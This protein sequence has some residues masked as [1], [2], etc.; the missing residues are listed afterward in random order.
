MVF[1][2]DKADTINALVEAINAIEHEL[3]IV[4]SGVYFD[5]R[6]RL[7]I[8]EARINNPN[9]PGPNAEN[10]FYIGN[11]GVTVSVGLGFPT[12]NRTPG[13][14]Y[15][16]QDGYAHEGFYS[17]RPDGYWYQIDNTVTFGGD[18][19]GGLLSQTVI[20][21]QGKPISSTAPSDGY[22]LIYNSLATQ[23]QPSRLAV[24][25]DPINYNIRSN[26][27]LLQSPINNTKVG[28]INFGTDTTQL[29]TGVTSNYGMILGGDKNVVS[30]DHGIVIGGLNNIVNSTYSIILDGYN[31][32]I[33]D[34]YT[35]SSITGIS[36]TIS[37]NYSN[38]WG[39]NNQTIADLTN[40]FGKKGKA[41]Y[42]GQ[43]VISTD[44]ISGNNGASQ[45]S[46][47]IVDGYGASGSQFDL[48][49]SNGNSNIN[50]ENGKSYDM[51]VKILI[52][53]TS[54]SPTCA[55]YI[56]DILAH[57]ESGTLVLDVVNVSVLNDN[58]TSWTVSFVTSGTAL[59]LR[60]N[61]SG[62][63][64]RRAIATIDWRELSRL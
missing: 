13:S 23:W 22:A 35:G 31:N 60:I 41:I 1:I 64:H 48:A 21:I 24:I 57:C 19:S 25:F 27:N 56:Y 38:T 46:K 2:D 17:R 37:G 39:T 33:T 14:I 12:E 43:F 4:P 40:V 10:P 49:M 54:G 16:R 11:S 7:D 18:L 61:S 58:G 42:P 55:R 36:N 29:T 30:K 62:S 20:G 32:T 34:G 5:V 3:G 50:L 9:I 47:L 52:N 51:S 53:N 28:I 26:K 45:L 63:F 8:L 6:A 15:L 59:I 44:S